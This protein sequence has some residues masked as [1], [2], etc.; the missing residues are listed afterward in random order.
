MGSS[1]I[2]DAAHGVPL[3]EGEDLYLYRE[4][5]GAKGGSDKASLSPIPEPES[6]VSAWGIQTQRPK[7]CDHLRSSD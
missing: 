3:G 1:A 6:G 2:V 5:G 7:R 4:D